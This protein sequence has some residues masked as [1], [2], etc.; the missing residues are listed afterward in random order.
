MKYKFKITFNLNK[1]T[2][3]NFLEKAYYL[4]EN[5][6]KITFKKNL[7]IIDTKKKI[8]YKKI[9]NLILKYLNSI[10][11]TDKR[12]TEEI[13]YESKWKMPNL[14]K[15]PYIILL[16]KNYIKKISNGVFSVEGDLL[17]LKEYLDKSLLNLISK[18]GYQNIKYSGIIPLNSIIDNKYLR[19]FPNHC[20]FVSNIKRDFNAIN[21]VSKLKKNNPKKLKNNL[22]FPLEILSP[23]VCFNC[24]ETFKN[25]KI[26]KPIKITAIENCHR[27]ESLNYKKLERLKVYSM[28]EWIFLGNKNFVQINLADLIKKFKKI[29]D[30]WKLKFR[31]CTASDPFFSNKDIQKK[32]FQYSNR[33]KYEL[34]IYLP[35]EKKW[36]AVASF[37]NHLDTIV[38]SYN[39]QFNNKKK[40]FSGCVGVGYERLLYGYFCQKG[41]NGLW[42]K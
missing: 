32:I 15:D 30:V 3:K 27:Y 42:K 34:Q 23:T 17:K 10:L 6:L 18:S 24:F 26:K 22:S 4:D 21:Q 5:I 7:I 40:I 35:F 9:K 12:F 36:L 14:K 1:N 39:I 38:K 37:N 8:N 11:E 16:K 33:L 25:K 19:S 20:I 2:Q 29:F 13:I 31:I 28:R 41:L